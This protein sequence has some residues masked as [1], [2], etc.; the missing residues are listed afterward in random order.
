MR[1][2]K[3]FFGKEDAVKPFE[4]F[5]LRIDSFILKY[6]MLESHCLEN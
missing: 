2:P 6:L 5:N 1:F 3:Y 4:G